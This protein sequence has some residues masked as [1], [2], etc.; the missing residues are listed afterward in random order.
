VSSPSPTPRLELTPAKVLGGRA[1]LA[2]SA[3]GLVL[4]VPVLAGSL[5]AV[6]LFRLGVW[7][8]LIPLSLILGASWLL[9]L[10]FG[11]PHIARLAASMPRPDTQSRTFLVQLTLS[12]R[13]R[14]G[15]RALLDDA[16]DVGWLWVSESA[17]EF[18]G[19]SVRLTLPL[20]R[21]RQVRR[22]SIGLRGLYL[23]PQL[24]LA[25]SGLTQASEIW[26]A[27]RASWLLPN[28]RRVTGEIFRLLSNTLPAASKAVQDDAQRPDGRTSSA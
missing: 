16:D 7:T 12:P 10:G 18:R 19:D 24:T 5:A 1:L 27:E 2:V 17:V 13:V 15:F 22:G 14:S 28:S 23:Y 3:Y 25:V 9:P 6:S 8:W 26:L 20:E 11:N 4:M 21:I